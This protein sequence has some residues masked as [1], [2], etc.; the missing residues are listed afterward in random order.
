MISYCCICVFL[1]FSFFTLFD[2]SAWLVQPSWRNRLASLFC[3]CRAQV[4]ETSFYRGQIHKDPGYNL[5]P[6]KAQGHLA[7]KCLILDLDETLVHSSFKPVPNPDF[8]I[9]LRLEGVVHYVYVLKRPFVDLFLEA[10]GEKFEI[11]MF[12]ASLPTYADAVVDRLDEKGYIHH[13][14][15]REHCVFTRGAFVKDLARLGRDV[16]QSVI[17]DN[18]PMS[19]SLHPQNAIPIPTWL[20]DPHD[21]YLRDLIPLLKRISDIEDIYSVLGC[22]DFMDLDTLMSQPDV[23]HNII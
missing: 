8:V 5:L 11:V 14:L 19:Y 21:T 22:L 7:K 6:R 17:I 18:S 10:V 4:E 23:R 16:S 9:P 1:F 15:F 20:D 2:L 12:T 3:C 13:R